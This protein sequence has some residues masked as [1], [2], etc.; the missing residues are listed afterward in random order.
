MNISLAHRRREKGGGRKRAKEREG[1]GTRTHTH[2]HILSL[3]LS[4]SLSTSRPLCA[5][6]NSSTTSKEITVIGGVTCCLQARMERKMTPLPPKV[7]QHAPAAICRRQP[8]AESRPNTH[9]L[10]SE[11]SERQRQRQRRVTCYRGTQTVPWCHST[12]GIPER[13]YQKDERAQ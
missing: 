5:S 3:S 13:S 6:G 9:Q 1:G 8:I 4:T 2:T 7:S 11:E 12:S 10:A